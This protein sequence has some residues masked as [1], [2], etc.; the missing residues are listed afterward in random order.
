MNK[1]LPKIV[2]IVG[3]VGLTSSLLYLITIP[4]KWNINLSELQIVEEIDTK[5]D[6]QNSKTIEDTKQIEEKKIMKEINNTDF[7]D[8]G[9]LTILLPNYFF[10]DDFISLAKEIEEKEKIIIKYQTID[11]IEEYKLFLNGGIDQ[12]ITADVFLI[13]SDWLQWLES[14]IKQIELEKNTGLHA[15]F[16]PIFQYVSSQEEYT[17]VPFSIDPLITFVSQEADFQSQ[18]VT[19]W[20]M[21]SF[22]ILN[23]TN[24]K[25]DMPLLRGVS[26]NDIRLLEN[27]RESF[28]H[29]FQILY[30]FLYQ[31]NLNG[32]T[33]ILEQF[34]KIYTNDIE[35]KRNY[36]KFKETIKKIE[37][38]NTNCS[39]FPNVC[40]FV[41][42]FGDIR[43]W[44]MSDLVIW[45][46]YFADST[47]KE[48]EVKLLNFPLADD[49]YKVRWR[50]FVINENNLNDEQ[51]QKFFQYYLKAWVNNSRNLWWK[52]ISA[53]TNIYN[54]QIQQ[55]KYSNIIKYEQKF[56]ILYSSI[57]LQ[58]D[59]FKKTS[60]IKFLKW[61][62]STDEFLKKIKEWSW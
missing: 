59:F 1:H 56:S 30:N 34:Q 42:K 61:N 3:I 23:K 13:P 36:I 49:V 16:H 18:R 12:K 60:A 4:S 32:N 19:V 5:L 28:P 10:N 43:F 62:I 9:K 11:N 51:I 47:R 8:D 54:L 25:T 40:L 57:D 20:N 27:E 41:Y 35:Y 52:N 26:K 15:Y 6:R 7:L 22:L 17:F 55:K 29:Y 53:F 21:L 46:K 2:L 39:I 50:G 31:I 33:E 45:E 48:N 58:K 37:K 14:N 44:F 24:R 38:R